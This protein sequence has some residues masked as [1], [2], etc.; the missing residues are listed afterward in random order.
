MIRRPTPRV[1]GYPAI[2]KTRSERPDAV[3]KRIPACAG[4]VRLPDIAIARHVRKAAVVIQIVS[5][6]R[7]GRI[8]AV[9][10][11]SILLVVLIL[12]LIP[13]VKGIWFDTLGQ[14]VVIII[15][16]VELGSVILA[17]CH[18]SCIA[19]NLHFAVEDG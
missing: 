1:A 6:V 11:A 10:G 17:N 5:A 19:L 16:K 14:F 18:G 13:F 15:R 7:V 3:Q 8:A 4:K 12:L 9:G 2:T